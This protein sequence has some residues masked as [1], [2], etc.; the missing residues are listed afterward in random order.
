V[1]LIISY[2]FS[3]TKLENNFEREVKEWGG[4]GVGK[5]CVG[6]GVAQTMYT[7]VSVKMIKIF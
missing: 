2:V 4:A 6:R 5:E 1:F 7:Y 3:S